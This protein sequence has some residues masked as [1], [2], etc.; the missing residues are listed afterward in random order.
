MRLV[1][2][3]INLTN[4]IAQSTTSSDATMKTYVAVK[5][6][7]VTQAPTATLKAIIGSLQA[8]ETE[9]VRE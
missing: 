4:I 3:N 5:V 9:S 6:V 8:G 2:D 1:L 7:T